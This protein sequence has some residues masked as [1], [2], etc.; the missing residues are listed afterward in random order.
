LLKT[1]AGRFRSTAARELFFYSGNNEKLA[2]LDELLDDL[3]LA[4]K[5][6]RNYSVLFSGVKQFYYGGKGGILWP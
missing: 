6:G 2:S 4:E 5:G 1:L 3:P